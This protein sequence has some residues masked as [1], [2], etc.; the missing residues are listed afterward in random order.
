MT[1]SPRNKWSPVVSPTTITADPRITFWSHCQVPGP[2]HD[3]D[4]ADP[5]ENPEKVKSKE[6]NLKVVNEGSEASPPRTPRGLKVPCMQ[7]E[8]GWN[9]QWALDFLLGNRF[10]TNTSNAFWKK[11]AQS[12]TKND[13]STLISRKS[14]ANVQFHRRKVVRERRR[15]FHTYFTMLYTPSGIRNEHLGPSS[16]SLTRVL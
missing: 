11:A 9:T 4:D 15:I 2:D 8:I 13:I 6:A 10:N 1:W 3:D 14:F 7:E 12:E 5:Y 16:D